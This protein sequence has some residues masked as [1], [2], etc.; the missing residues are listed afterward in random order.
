MT[1]TLDLQFPADHPTA[2]G[3]FPG[4]PIIPGAMLLDAVGLALGISPT[5]VRAAKFLRPVRPGETVQLAWETQ[6]GGETRFTC[7]LDG[8]TVLTGTIE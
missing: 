2:A 8:A 4:N 5:Q 1:Q 7:Q 3:H 6:A